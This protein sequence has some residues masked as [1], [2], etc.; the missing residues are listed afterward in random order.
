MEG[1][2]AMGVLIPFRV[3]ILKMHTTHLLLAA[4]SDA[5]FL[6]VA[7]TLPKLRFALTTCETK[8]LS[9]SL[10]NNVYFLNLT[11]FAFY[12]KTVEARF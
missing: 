9:V 8:T 3:P 4:L 5:F 7:F 1:G 6:I 10:L 2:K 11:M 12:L